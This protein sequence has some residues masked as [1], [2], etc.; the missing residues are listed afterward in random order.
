MLIQ[1]NMV[2]TY[3]KYCEHNHYSLSKSKLV[4]LIL[5]AKIMVIKISPK[6]EACKVY[7]PAQ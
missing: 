5:S 2:L 4:F 3:F 6:C 7:L 1:G